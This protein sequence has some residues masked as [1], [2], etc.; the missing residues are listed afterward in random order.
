MDLAAAN[1][2]GLSLLK[3]S[4]QTL[5]EQKES[6]KPVTLKTK[7]EEQTKSKLQ[8]ERERAISAEPSPRQR[9]ESPMKRAA[10]E[11]KST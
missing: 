10:E 6:G 4:T 2:A 5:I 7:L 1:K 11:D 3:Q 8:V 9:H